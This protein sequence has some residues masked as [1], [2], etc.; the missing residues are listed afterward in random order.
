[1]R[2]GSEKRNVWPKVK[3]ELDK[4]RWHYQRIEDKFTP[5]IPDVNIHVPRFGD[6][7]VELKYVEKLPRDERHN[8]EIGLRPEQYIWLRDAKKAGRHVHLL[9]KVGMGWYVW[10]D[11]GAWE[12]AKRPSPWNE[13]RSKAMQFDNVESAVSFVSRHQQT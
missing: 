8:I 1:M 9:A 12:L 4:L 6:V 11:A 7:W 13:L 2:D 5:G 3:T 10:S